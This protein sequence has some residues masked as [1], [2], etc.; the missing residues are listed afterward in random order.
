M[1]SKKSDHL[2]S[3]GFGR[4]PYFFPSFF[5]YFLCETSVPN[6]IVL[7]RKRHEKF[8]YFFYLI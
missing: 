7:V 6:K 4:S 8:N 5:I 3:K 1:E 2:R